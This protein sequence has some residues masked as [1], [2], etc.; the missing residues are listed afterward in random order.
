M[1]MCAECTQHGCI[2]RDMDKTMTCCPCKNE[3]IQKQA[4]ELYNE[5]ENL[6]IALS[7]AIVEAE[8]YAKI[9]RVEEIVLFCQKAGY[10]KIGLVFCM[11]LK[12]EAKIVSKIF[13]HH[14]L[15]VVSVICKNGSV[16]KS[17]IGVTAEHTLSGCTE[18]VMCNPI[19]QALLMNQE[20]VD[21]NV[22]LGLCVGHDTL[23]LKYIEAPTTVLAVK[24]RLTGHNPI[25]AI[26]MAE[27]YHKGRIFKK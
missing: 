12:N 26:N 15:E 3:E 4:A 22:L 23:A 7:S 21:F 6:N 18:E 19:G 11:G 1:Y 24:D 2:L 20:K 25:A 9:S 5:P 16:P 17:S 13:R 14:G 27:G 8:G 10:K